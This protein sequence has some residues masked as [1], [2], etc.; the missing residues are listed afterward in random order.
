MSAFDSWTD[1][2][3]WDQQPRVIRLPVLSTVDSFR[4]SVT[5]STIVASPYSSVGLT[6]ASMQAALRRLRALGHFSRGLILM[7]CCL[8][9]WAFA[10]T[11]LEESNL[12]PALSHAFTFYSAS[13]QSLSE[14]SSYFTLGGL[15]LILL[16]SLAYSRCCRVHWSFV[17]RSGERHHCYRRVKRPLEEISVG[18]D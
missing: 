18:I 17:M 8:A 6:N 14:Q 11:A 16:A 4:S 9:G 3:L 7:I 15:L 1:F 13:R 5:C 2:S 10:H 12:H